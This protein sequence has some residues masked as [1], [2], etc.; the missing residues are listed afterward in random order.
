MNNTYLEVHDL[1]GETIATIDDVERFTLGT[2]LHLQGLKPLLF[3][4]GRV[5]AELQRSFMDPDID[6]WSGRRIVLTPIAGEVHVRADTRQSRI[7]PGP[8][9]IK[10]EGPGMV[11]IP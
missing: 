1:R 9:P 4:D 6:R 10:S 2:V 8:L 3:R 7:E 11:W 5:M